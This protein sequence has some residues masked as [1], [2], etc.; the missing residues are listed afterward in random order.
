[1]CTKQIAR[2]TGGA[3]VGGVRDQRGGAGLGIEHGGGGHVTLT[4]THCA[5]EF[6]V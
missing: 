2:E 1:M 5:S 6:W 3:E 4:R